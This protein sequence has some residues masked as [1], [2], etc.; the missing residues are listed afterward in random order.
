MKKKITSMILASL[1]M[2]LAASC[3]FPEQDYTAATPPIYAEQTATPK[4]RQTEAQESSVPTLDLDPSQLS[5][6]DYPLYMEVNGNEPYFS[7][8]DKENVTAFELYS[9]LDELL[10]CGVAYANVCQE[11]MPTEERGAIGMI[12]P[13]G[14]LTVRYDDII[15]GKYLY[16]RCHLIGFQLAGENANER[17]L[18]TGTRHLNVA[19][20]LPFENQVADYVHETNNHVLYRVTPCFK[21]EELVARAVL[22]EAY[23]VEDNGEGCKFC[24]LCPNW[25]PGVGI[26]YA[27]GYSWRV[28]HGLE[29][30]EP[31]PPAGEM[32]YILNTRSR[33]FHLPTCNNAADIADYN[34]EET[35]KTRT[36]LISE[37]YTPCGSCNP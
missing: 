36:T 12:R 28:E 26:D 11:L 7:D 2:A 17:N 33:K 6:E 29:S 16:N 32:T 4:P 15:D 21:G 5:T 22:M 1:L 10:R 9:P 24:V 18:I 37:G 14:W 25:Q 13:S 23:S 35:R 27:T 19:S 20:M 34:R 30:P 8:E 31:E 3:A